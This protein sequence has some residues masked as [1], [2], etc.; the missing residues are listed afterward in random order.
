MSSS[1]PQVGEYLTDND[2]AVRLVRKVRITKWMALLETISYCGLLVPMYRKHILHDAGNLNYS[3]LRIVAYFHGIIAAAFAVMAF[4]IRRAM[5]WS[6]T[7]FVVALLGPVGAMIAHTR[8]RK[9]PIP[10]DVTNEDMYF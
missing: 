2:P 6:W 5:K 7:F 4:D 10:T 9:Q 1:T 8:L 3:V